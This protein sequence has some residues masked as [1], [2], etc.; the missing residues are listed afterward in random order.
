MIVMAI[1]QI[2]MHRRN[3]HG[4]WRNGEDNAL[5]CNQP[6]TGACNPLRRRQGRSATE[7]SAVT[8]CRIETATPEDTDTANTG[9]LEDPKPPFT[10]PSSTAQVRLAT[11]APQP[12]NHT[13]R[14]ASCAPRLA[15][16]HANA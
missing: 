8:P 13:P 1:A 2:H 12:R 7:A 5:D 15:A 9:T 16:S 4:S 6:Y 10:H 3:R 14:H 11:S